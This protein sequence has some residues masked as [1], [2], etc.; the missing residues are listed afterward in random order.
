MANMAMDRIVA[1]HAE[2]LIRTRLGSG[3]PEETDVLQIGPAPTGQPVVIHELFRDLGQCSL[4]VHALGVG[5]VIVEHRLRRIRWHAETR[6][7]AVSLVISPYQ[8]TV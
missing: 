6:N 8:P 2:S 1:N 3:E 4:A 5:Q 7:R